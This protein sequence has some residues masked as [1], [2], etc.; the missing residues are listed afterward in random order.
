MFSL[1]N[2]MGREERS[3]LLGECRQIEEHIKSLR[4]AIKNEDHFNRQVEMNATIKELE[5]QL[6]ELMVRL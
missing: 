4:N 5:S 2:G 1:D 6:E 3:S